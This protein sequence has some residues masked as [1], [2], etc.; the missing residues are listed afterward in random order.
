MAKDPAFLFYPNDYMGGTMGMTFEEKGAYMDLLILQFNKGPFTIDQAKKVLNGSFEKLWEV[1]GE[2]FVEQSGKYF[3][4]RLESEKKKRSEFSESRRKNRASKKTSS[5]H[6]EDMINT[7]FTSVKHMSSH[8]ENENENRNEVSTDLGKE[9][10]LGEEKP[11]AD[12]IL[13]IHLDARTLDAAEQN[14]FTFT[15]N[16][17]TEF[18]KSQWEIFKMERVHDPPLKIREYTKYNS[19]LYSHFLNWIRNKFPKTNGTH[20]S[21]SSTNGKAGRSEIND[22]ARSNY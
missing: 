2:K 19:K 9:E 21:S 15:K 14:Q 1:I 17:N 13:K 10:G 12:P 16:R 8:M 7:S 3:N 20:I 18:I 5:T 11:N 22:R 6:D 4:Q